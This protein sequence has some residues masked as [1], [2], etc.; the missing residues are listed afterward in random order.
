MQCG[1]ATKTSLSV[2]ADPIGLLLPDIFGAS[3][4]LAASALKAGPPPISR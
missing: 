2:D 3:A 1:S 4:A